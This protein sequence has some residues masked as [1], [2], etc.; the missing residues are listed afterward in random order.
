MSEFLSIK[1]NPYKKS[2]A[3]LRKPSGTNDWVTLS[4][5]SDLKKLG[6]EQ[7]RHSIQNCA[8]E[9]IE[10]YKNDY[11]FGNAEN[12]IVFSGTESD[13]KDFEAVFNS[14][15]IQQVKLIFNQNDILSE[16]LNA[17]SV[18]KDAYE[19]IRQEFVDFLPDSQRFSLLSES[20]KSI[21]KKIIR[22]ENIIK[23]E[24]NICVIGNYSVGKS[25]FINA[26][27]G[28]ELLPSAA[29]PTTARVFRII[30]DVKNSIVFT[31][32]DKKILIRWDKDKYDY[33]CYNGDINCI[34][35]IAKLID[36]KARIK[37]TAKEQMQAILKVLNEAYQDKE[38]KILNLNLSKVGPEVELRVQYNNS[39][40]NFAD[41]N[42]VIMDT[43]GSN[44]GTYADVH[45]KVLTN[46][47]QDQTNS[48]P[49]VLLER[50]NLDSTDNETLEKALNSVGKQ[51]DI[52]NKIIVINKADEIPPYTLEQGINKS[53]L[54]KWRLNKIIFVS[55][56]IA[57]GFKKEK[58]VWSDEAYKY[59]FDTHEKEFRQGAEY[60][61]PLNKYAILPNNE[62]V[63]SDVDEMYIN[64]GMYTLENEI[65]YFASKYALYLKSEEACNHLLEALGLVESEL[66]KLNETANNTKEA[67]ETARSD[68]KKEVI[69]SINSDVVSPNETQ[70][71]QDDAKERFS[72]IIEQ[73]K[74]T[75]YNESA[76]TWEIIDKK[77]GFGK[78]ESKTK[79]FHGQMITYCNDYY[80]VIFPEVKNFMIQGLD[81]ISE[82]HKKNILNIIVNDEEL[83]DTAKEFLEKTKIDDPEFD[84]GYD[85]FDAD[86]KAFSSFLGIFGKWVNA[87]KYSEKLKEQFDINFAN[88]CIKSPLDKMKKTLDAWLN[89]TKVKYIDNIDE[90]SLTL[91]KFDEEISKL[92]TE[93]QNLTGRISNLTN[94]K[95]SLGTLLEFKEEHY[96]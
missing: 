34:N 32:C 29:D 52:A 40:L 30:N 68:K 82:T 72:N 47:L 21:G 31:Y 43:P 94:T 55:S 56:I 58:G 37:K 78:G 85:K 38:G 27:L 80:K 19:S 93:I 61:K 65:N 87:K 83:T 20:Q 70:K 59:A 74:D 36:E 24:I 69:N 28:S 39:C 33:E 91:K 57:L 84:A 13:F 67:Y 86:I 11:V 73:F 1:Y 25:T 18:I 75:F 16:A 48:L 90:K 79:E 17:F 92:E 7:G 71:V 14:T 66:D 96:E 53:V 62:Q 4:K 88:N 42:F 6:F 44:A 64:S 5:N 10:A 89:E 22:F 63:D 41:Y 46:A 35:D 60:F 76:S 26:L 15:S 81:K 50:N 95:K 9:I 12:T 3:F 54:Q 49:I 45:A 8:K 77:H 51:V 2:I 23:P